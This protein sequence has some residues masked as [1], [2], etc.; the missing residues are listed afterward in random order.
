ME[1]KMDKKTETVFIQ[2]CR[3]KITNNIVLGSLHTYGIG[4]GTVHYSDLTIT[5]VTFL[6]FVFDRPSLWKFFEGKHISNM[7]DCITQEGTG[8][9]IE[10][11][12]TIDIAL[13]CGS[14]AMWGVFKFKHSSRL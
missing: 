5:L 14:F 12:S 7:V 11:V 1:K 6:A 8:L 2:G 9:R 13:V 4:Y 3:G 10:S